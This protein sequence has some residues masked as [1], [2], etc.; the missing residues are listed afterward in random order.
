MKKITYSNLQVIKDQLF[1]NINN[2]KRKIIFDAWSIS[3]KQHS[4]ECIRVLFIGK[5]DELDKNYF[6]SL[7]FNEN[8]DE[9]YLGKV[10]IWRI[11]FFFWRF[12]KNHDLIIIKTKMNICNIFKS[13]KRF[14]I[15][16]WISCEIDIGCDFGS[17]SISK[18]LKNNFRK[19]KRS[20][21]G[22]TITKD[23]LDFNFF[24]NDMYLP[25][26][27]NRHGNLGLEI[28]LEKMKRSFED[29][30][31]LLIKD[32][33][34]II[35]GVLIDYKVMNGVP[36][37]TQLGVLRGDSKYVKKGALIAIYYYT[38]EYLRKR[39]NEKLSLGLA[40]PFIYDGLLNHKLSWGAKI[41]CETS[42][43]FLLCILSHKKSLKTFLLN[44]PFICNDRNSLSL[45]TFTKGNS[46]EDK[47]FD[48]YRKKLNK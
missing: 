36:R 32:E 24:Y 16:N 28:S 11:F 12:R 35:A 19:I 44:N 47:Q 10:R 45:A 40:R 34:E 41:V 4:D 43:A 3:S 29:G 33:Q 13:K 14:V 17:Q 23:P 26:I 21:F 37:I 25:Y 15:P 1:N 30:E 38:I 20:N 5:G 7:I 48:K 18:S 6:R 46:R 9:N 2:F 39:N 8:Y 31:L 42:Y 27:K 22:Y